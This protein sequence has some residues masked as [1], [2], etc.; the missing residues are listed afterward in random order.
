MGSGVLTPAKREPAGGSTSPPGSGNG[1][2]G[3][4]GDSGGNGHR[5]PSNPPLPL[6]AYKIAIWIAIISISM[7]FLAL[8][9]VMVARATGA[10]DW[11]HTAVPS[12]LYFNTFILLASS[13]TFELSKRALRREDAKR[14]VR[15]LYFT[16]GL[17]LA[18]VAGQLIAWKQ[19]SDRGIYLTTNT[20]SSFLYL[21]TA[22]HGL[23][24]LGGIIGL[25][26]LVLR[27]RKILAN[28][29]KRIAVEITSIYWH[30][31][32]VLWIYLFVLLVVKL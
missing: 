9:V 6:G 4:G 16:T 25:F 21:L 15:W 29:R 19:L 18:F 13:F 2:R 31:M 8:T 23:H 12:I 5:G 14:F 1:G 3:G 28:P 27:T 11:V 24:L 26:Y 10:N 7:L 20:S 32:D 30:F 17:G 22:A